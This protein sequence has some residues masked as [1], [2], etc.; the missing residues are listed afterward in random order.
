MNVFHASNSVGLAVVVLLTNFPLVVR[1]QL[2]EP[3]GTSWQRLTEVMEWSFGFAIVCP[4]EISGTNCP[5]QPLQV[6]NP[7]LFMLCEPS[8]DGTDEY[9]TCLINC[10]GT[11]FEVLPNESL[12]LDGFTLQGST[13]SAIDVHPMASFEAYHST[14]IK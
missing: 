9:P 10:P 8:F 6:K 4:F 7:D 3:V 14:F 12:T 2:C 13:S 1:S 11:H 5:D